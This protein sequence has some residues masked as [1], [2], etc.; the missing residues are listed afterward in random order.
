VRKTVRLINKEVHCE[1]GREYNWLRGV[2]EWPLILVVLK[3]QVL[4]T[5]KFP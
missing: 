5:A 1:D 2:Q 4:Q 3:W